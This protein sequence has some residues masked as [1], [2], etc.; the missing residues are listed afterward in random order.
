MTKLAAF[1][2]GL[3]QQSDGDVVMSTIADLYRDEYPS[4]A[5]TLP[6]NTPT[7]PGQAQTPTIVFS[8]VELSLPHPAMHHDAH[9]HQFPSLLRVQQVMSPP[10]ASAVSFINS[11]ISD[12]D[13]AKIPPVSRRFHANNNNIRDRG[14]Q[15]TAFN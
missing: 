8:A 2:A 9:H 7:L 11:W 10:V 5:G 13:I 12:T 6:P 1:Q 15:H 4:P 14:Q 3:R